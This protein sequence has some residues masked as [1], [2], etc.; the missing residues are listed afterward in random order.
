VPDPTGA[1]AQG[2]FNEAV[3]AVSMKANEEG[4]DTAPGPRPAT[5]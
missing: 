1:G 2:D 4:P 3:R 5:T